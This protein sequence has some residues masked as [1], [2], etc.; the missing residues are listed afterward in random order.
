[1]ALS[2]VAIIVVAVIVL[3]VATHPRRCILPEEKA[4]P[5]GWFAGGR[6]GPGHRV[7]QF[8]IASGPCGPYVANQTERDWFPVVNPTG[9]YFPAT[10]FDSVLCLS[11]DLGVVR[12]D[13]AKPISKCGGLRRRLLRGKR[14]SA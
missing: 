9:R 10:A 7:P 2:L 11:S 4:A 13:A 3:L 1:M 12:R 8:T 5:D 6:E 14:S